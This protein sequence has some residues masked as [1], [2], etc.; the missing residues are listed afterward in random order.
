MTSAELWEEQF[1]ERLEA[2]DFAGR[3]IR[4]NEYG[5]HSEHGWTLDH[6]L[7]LAMNGPDAWENVQITHW[8]TN[9]EKADKNPFRANGKLFQIKKIKN[10]YDEDKMANYPYKRCGK[11]YCVIIID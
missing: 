9:E 4:K 11:R 3:L 8:K 2:N 1:K 6:I 7:P 5:I 10:L